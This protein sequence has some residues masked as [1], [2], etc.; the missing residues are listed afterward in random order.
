M[1][2]KSIGIMET[3]FQVGNQWIYG[4]VKQG[5]GEGL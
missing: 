5:R 4:E 2:D 3:I 1:V